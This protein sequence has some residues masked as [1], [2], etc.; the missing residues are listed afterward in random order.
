M[1]DMFLIDYEITRERMFVRFDGIC[2]LYAT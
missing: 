2:E 1:Y